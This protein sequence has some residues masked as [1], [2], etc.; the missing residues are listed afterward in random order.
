MPCS[1]AYLDAPRSL[2]RVVHRERFNDSLAGVGFVDGVATAGMPESVFARLV[3]L[4]V[5]LSDCGPWEPS[6]VADALATLPTEPAAAAP[7]AAPLVA[8]DAAPPSPVPSRRR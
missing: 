4:G 8:R 2:R 5:P 6:A 1:E 3:G 7:L